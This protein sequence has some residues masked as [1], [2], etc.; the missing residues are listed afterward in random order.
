MFPFSGAI[1]CEPFAGNFLN[2]VV[3]GTAPNR[4]GL[5][6]LTNGL[7]ANNNSTDNTLQVKFFEATS[8]IEIHITRANTGARS[9]VGVE[10][11]V[12]HSALPH[13]EGTISALRSQQGREKL[14]FFL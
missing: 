4:V 2:Y 14:A 12:A 11:P 10:G 1:F 13:R 7:S 8:D 5:L 6:T 9:T 3:T